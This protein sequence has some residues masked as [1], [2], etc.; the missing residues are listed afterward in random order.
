[1]STKEKEVI[2]HEDSDLIPIA[3]PDS[4]LLLAVEQGADLDKL[5]KLMDLKERHDA[6]IARKEYFQAVAAFK[7]DPIVIIKDKVNSQYGSRYTSKGNLVNT[8][9]VQLSKFGLTARWDVHQ[10][11]EDITVTCILSHAEGHSEQVSLTAPP[12]ESGSKNKIQQIK[13]TKTYLEIATYEAVT[14]VAS[15]DDP[16]DT[17]GNMPQETITDEQ[18]ANL[19]SLISE[20]GA[21]KKQF[22]KFLQR[23]KLGDLPASKYEN[24]VERLQEKGKAG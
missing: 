4:L 24:A 5:E 13:S 14:G 22:L 17:D 15:T 10:E 8:V 12:D 3:S 1:M 21:N 7:A 2:Q 18:V 23:E 6:G 9:N 16:G 19:E 11:A 20:V